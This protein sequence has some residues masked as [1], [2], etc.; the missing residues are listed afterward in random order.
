MNHYCLCF[1]YESLVIPFNLLSEGENS[2]T[3]LSNRDDIK[4]LCEYLQM[5]YV[6]LPYVSFKQAIN[7]ST[8]TK[9]KIN[10]VINSLDNDN[11]IIHFTHKNYD[12]H[13]LFIALC[14]GKY[15]CRFHRT[16]MDLEEVYKFNYFYL[17]SL[18]QFMKYYFLYLCHY[19]IGFK[20]KYGLDITYRIVFDQIV[21]NIKMKSLIESGVNII[22]YPDKDAFFHSTY[23]RMD[24]DIE[25]AD[26]LFLVPDINEYK[27][28]VSKDSL[29]KFI[30]YMDSIENVVYKYHPNRKVESYKKQYPKFIPAELIIPKIKNNIISPMSFAFRY[31]LKLGINRTISTLELLDWTDKRQ[32][33]IF[34][35]L[36]V[37]WGCSFFPKNYEELEFLIKG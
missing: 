36:L 12:V 34:K 9:N 16:E 6:Q 24:L 29:D 32:K 25:S 15:E 7:D 30:N 20:N 27:S 23:S 17:S 8:E 3:I 37:S 1:G 14:I 5:N 11:S 13:I 10:K 19:R 28:W 2:V 21:P 33:K 4:R 35:N 18:K 26:N 31:S 22:D